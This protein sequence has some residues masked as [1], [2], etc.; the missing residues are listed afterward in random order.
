MKYMKLYETAVP[1]NAVC[2]T[3]FYNFKMNRSVS[4]FDNVAELQNLTLKAL[5]KKL[6]PFYR[7]V[8]DILL[9]RGSQRGYR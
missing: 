2:A 9:L 5:G 4:I 6:I 7:K 8:C 3:K 1:K